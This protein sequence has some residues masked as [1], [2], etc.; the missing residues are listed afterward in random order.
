VS[1][2]IGEQPDLLAEAERVLV[3]CAMN[4]VAIDR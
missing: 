3:A 1:R 4:T 2:R